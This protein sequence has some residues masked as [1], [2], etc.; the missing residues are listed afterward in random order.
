MEKK[1]EKKQ[2]KK[3]SQVDPSA[4]EAVLAEPTTS[5]RPARGLTAEERVELE[6]LQ[7]EALDEDK[8]MEELRG[9]IAARDAK[10][11]KLEAR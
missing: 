11:R 2:E 1:K 6:Q 8:E 5:A 4:A 10:I 3:R 9:L 7:A